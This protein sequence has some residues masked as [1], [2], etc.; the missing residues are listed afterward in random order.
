[1]LSILI[2]GAS[3]VLLG[4]FAFLAWHARLLAMT[5]IS[6]SPV[7]QRAMAHAPAVVGEEFERAAELLRVCPSLPAWEEANLMAVRVYYCV[8][9]WLAHVV[10]SPTRRQWAQLDMAACGHYVALKLDQKL[11]GNAA[12]SVQTHTI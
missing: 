9:R 7:C 8:T 1:M 12:H 4:R 6:L 5:Q 2:L 11:H 10:S 3:A